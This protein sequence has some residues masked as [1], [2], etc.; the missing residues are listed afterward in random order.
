[1]L[2]N[3]QINVGMPRRLIAE[4]FFRN[5]QLYVLDTFQKILVWSSSS[6]CL[7]LA[8]AVYMSVPKTL[9]SDVMDAKTL[10]TVLGYLFCCL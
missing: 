1:V 3:F 2:V 8:Y 9:S 10:Y 6:A 7:F 5:I 4:V